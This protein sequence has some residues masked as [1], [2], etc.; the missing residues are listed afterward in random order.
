[1][2]DEFTAFQC[3]L[4]DGK[5]VRLPEYPIQAAGLLWKKAGPSAPEDCKE[6][7]LFLW[8]LKLNGQ[9][10]I[11]DCFYEKSFHNWITTKRC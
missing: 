8:M 10:W 9:G 7:T 6:M 2:R 4:P 1:M 3:E 11:R 5:I